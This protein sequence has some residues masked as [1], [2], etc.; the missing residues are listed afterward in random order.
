MSDVANKFRIARDAVSQF[1]TAYF[2]AEGTPDEGDA[3]MC[4]N[5]LAAML[6]AVKKTRMPTNLE[7]LLADVAPKVAAT[8]TPPVSQSTTAQEKA[9]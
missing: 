3:D 2:A 7:P 8:S 6:R 5:H 4:R 9:K 1:V